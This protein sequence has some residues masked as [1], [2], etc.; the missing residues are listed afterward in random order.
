MS[1][2]TKDFN[3][4][5]VSKYS[6]VDFDCI[7]ALVELALDDK[8]SESN[9]GWEMSLSKEKHDA[10][11]YTYHISLWKTNNEDESV[12][13]SFYTGID[14]GCELVDYSLGGLSLADK[15]MMQKVL[16]DLE[17][18]LSRMKEGVN[19]SLVQSMLDGYKEEIMEIYSKQNYDNYVTSGGTSSTNKYYKEKLEKFN[20]RGL[21]WNCLYR[22]E[23]F[24]RNFC[25]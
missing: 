19:V 15:P 14:V 5:F 16:Y 1:D 22:D 2:Q 17:L 3:E 7:W 18:D 25:Y 6:T 8:D 20:E 21:Y 11:N 4:D 12:E 23:E 24:D 9:N 10:L 13:L